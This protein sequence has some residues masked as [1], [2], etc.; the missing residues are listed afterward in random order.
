M[1]EFGNQKHILF[2]SQ[3]MS[4]VVTFHQICVRLDF[5]L[6]KELSDFFFFIFLYI[7]ALD[8][9]LCCAVRTSIDAETI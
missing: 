4:N 7:F 2:Y 6:L 1:A 9:L 5:L 3:R 8:L